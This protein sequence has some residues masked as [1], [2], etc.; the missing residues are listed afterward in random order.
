MADLSG[1]R[2]LAHLADTPSVSW[3][4]VVGDLD[5]CGHH[6]ETRITAEACKR[7]LIRRHEC[8][9][10]ETLEDGTIAHVC[11]PLAGEGHE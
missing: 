3:Y 4:E 9:Y 8:Q 11:Y 5:S 2:I 1:L 10:C 7:A 6:H